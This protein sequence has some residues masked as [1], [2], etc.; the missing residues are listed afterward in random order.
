MSVFLISLPVFIIIFA[1]WFFRKIK[2]ANNDWVHFLNNFAYYVSLPALI[3]ASLWDINFLDKNSQ[4]IVL[5]SLISV[6]LFS[7]LIFAALYF[8]KIRKSLKA[9]IFLAA[10]VG[11]TVYMGFPLIELGFG[12]ENLS[13]GALVALI[14]LIVPLLA[15]IFIIKYWHDK[16]HS[17]SNQ[18]KDFL[19]NPLVI[20]TLVGF[21]ISFLKID[22]PLIAAIKKSLSM[23]GATASPVALFALGGF[24]YG[25]FLKKDL[26]PVFG[27]SLLKTIAFPLVV[28]GVSF[29]LFKINHLGIFT[30]LSSMPVAVTTFVIAEKFNNEKEL[31]GNSIF[32]SIIFSFVIAPIIIYLFS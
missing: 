20:S 16:T 18:L 17:I 22:F 25:R 3:T 19:K 12:K 9:G 31:I 30:L 7:F 4:K 26:W 29:Y 10:T 6:I 2:V 11:N 5:F 15:A 32:L 1:G 24:I 13:N 14:Y 8:L 23:L 21:A 28:V 27:V